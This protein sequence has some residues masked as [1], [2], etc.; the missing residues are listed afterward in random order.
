MNR[1]FV[2]F[3]VLF[4]VRVAADGDDADCGAGRVGDDDG[5]SGD[6]VLVLMVARGAGGLLCLAGPPP[7]A[8]TLLRGRTVVGGRAVLQHGAA[9]GRV[10]LH[11]L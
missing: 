8:A 7:A 5:L 3:P 11:P 2:L 4:L 6:V 1:P 10:L 9:R